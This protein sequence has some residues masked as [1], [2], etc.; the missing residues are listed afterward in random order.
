M[1]R[2]KKIK[3]CFIVLTLVLSIL[4]SSIAAVVADNDGSAFITKKEFEALKKDFNDQIQS[5]NDSINNKIDGA[6]AAY[7]AGIRLDQV[8]EIL[9]DKYIDIVGM[10][11]IFLNQLPGTGQAANKSQISVNV[12]REEAVNK[13]SNLKFATNLWTDANYRATADSVLY[14]GTDPAWNGSYTDWTQVWLIRQSD[15]KTVETAEPMDG[16]LSVWTHWKNTTARTS[17]ISSYESI[18]DMSSAGSGQ[19]FIYQNIGGG[20][21]LKFYDT[22]IFP[23]INILTNYLIVLD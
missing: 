23:N 17:A 5:Y 15:I 16:A 21:I 8:P 13:F 14:F 2:F 3:I 9:Y 10:K 6:I 19:G 7:L 12:L 22:K 1:N 18:S 4:S 20:K 11:P